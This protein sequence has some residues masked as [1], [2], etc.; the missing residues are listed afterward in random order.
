VAQAA[1]I[2]VGPYSS[3]ALAAW[4]GAKTTVE[5]LVTT[6]S[7]RM[8]ARHEGRWLTAGA[9]ATAVV[10][11]GLGQ[12]EEALA[13]AEEAATGA[14]G[15]GLTAWSMVEL[16]EAAVRLRYPERAYG[17]V[18]RLSEIAA[19]GES[20]WVR[21]LLARSHALI[22]ED[23]WRQSWL[24]RDCCTGNGFVGKCAGGTPAS[25]C[26]KRIRC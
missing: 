9:W 25:S 8:L 17:A 5:R 4:T 6:G 3:L 1:E 14:V 10:S 12:Y 13:A 21:G 26:A 19:A 16:I 2:T 22:A 11:N 18:V 15:L 7:P 20:D 23:G 24:A